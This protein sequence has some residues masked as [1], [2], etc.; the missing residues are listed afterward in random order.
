MLPWRKLLLAANQ[1][2]LT[3]VQF[4]ALSV[5][6]WRA[7]MGEGQGLDSARLGE[8]CRD[9]PDAQSGPPS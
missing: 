6:E 3:P 9:F 7:L 1:F 4:W 2:G 5:F 8:L